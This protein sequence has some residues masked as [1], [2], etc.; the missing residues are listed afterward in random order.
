MTKMNRS[1]NEHH[2]FVV[3]QT[4]TSPSDDLLA[5]ALGCP[6]EE[7]SVR[8]ELAAIDPDILLFDGFDSAIIGTI[9]RCGQPVL[10]AYDYD[11]C[12]AE[13]V[14]RDGM[15]AE[16]AEEHM[17]YNVEGGWVGDRTP[18]VVHRLGSGDGT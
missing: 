3:A 18:C 10:A 15:T 6:I 13:L 8:R 17:T 12:I 5:E 16:E 7:S 4:V 11:R 1:A 2:R 9:H 14:T